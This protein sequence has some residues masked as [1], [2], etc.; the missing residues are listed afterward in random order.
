MP[1]VLYGDLRVSLDPGESVL[2]GLLRA[3]ADVAHAC[4]SGA[5][6]ACALQADPGSV[7]EAAQQGL[8][9]NERRRGV[10][11]SCQCRPQADLE[12]RP[13]DHADEVAAEVI[14]RFS[15]GPRVTGL[16]LRPEAPLEYL[17]GQYVALRRA[18]GLTRSY[19]LAS[20]PSE[21]LLEL[22]VGH[23]LGGRMS[24]WV[25][26]E[27]QP[28]ER[29]TLRGPYGECVYAP[30]QPE[31]PL[32]LVGVGTGAAPLWGV[33]REALAA[34][35]RGSITVVE[36]AAEPEGLYLHDA[37]RELAASDERL[38]L[39]SCVLRGGGGE[40]IEAAVDEVAAELF[41]GAGS[42]AGALAL[43]C[44]D[45]PVVHKTRRSLFLAGLSSRRILA[46]AFV[47]GP[48]PAGAAG[49]TGTRG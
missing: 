1:T 10:F 8:R 32:L 22:H 44:G 7:P 45:P 2:D 14:E 27:V 11:L 13:A 28:G 23:V 9:D 18:D 20:R 5:C 41:E 33:A 19:S 4:R 40:V 37:W 17:A 6:K 15:L 31:A 26:D 21:A 38:S 48:P 34:G 29:V 43:L 35:H 39:R 3:G 47:V 25:R 30:E 42:P 12:V 24:G 49:A 16:R 36:A 46:D